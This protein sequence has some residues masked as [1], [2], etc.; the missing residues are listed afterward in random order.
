MSD[1]LHERIKEWLVTIGDNDICYVKKDPR[2]I[3]LKHTEISKED[4]RLLILA[5]E[6]IRTVA[7]SESHSDRLIIEFDPENSIIP[8][9]HFIIL[10]P[11]S[12][13]LEKKYKNKLAIVTLYPSKQRL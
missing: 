4:V 1:R 6:K 5:P 3:F 11:F 9:V 2:T 10:D 13:Q 12:K 8:P 7:R